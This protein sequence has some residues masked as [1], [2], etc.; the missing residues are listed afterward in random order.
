MVVSQAATASFLWCNIAVI[1]N[2][3]AALLSIFSSTQAFHGKM[4][5]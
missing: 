4:R 1:K 5:P 3:D 2:V